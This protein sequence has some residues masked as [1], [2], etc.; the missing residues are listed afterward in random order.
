MP[1]RVSGLQSAG[2]Q[3]VVNGLS[4][5]PP[6]FIE[7]FPARWIICGFEFA[8][9]I[10]V[11]FDSATP[12]VVKSIRQRELLNTWLRLYARQQTAPAIWEYQPARLEEELADLVYYTVDTSTEPPQ[13]TI[14]SEGTRISNAYGH[15][16]KGRLLDDYVGPTLAP[17]VMPIYYKCA[18][19]SL[20]V[21]TISD[22]DD[23]YGRVVAYERL[24]LPFTTDNRVSH[25]VASLKTISV[26][27]GFEIKNLMRGNDALPR[28]RVRA[29]IDRDLFHRA[30]GRIAAADV[31]EFAEQPDPAPPAKSSS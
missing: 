22:I 30:P 7:N 4:L 5:R 31:I 8:W 14:Q 1:I 16:G 21:Y 15:T 25:I 27:G 11:N 20:P 26:D 23:I 13:L 28:P 9:M 2:R 24:L 17:F 19:Y 12:S 6:A 18:A 29:V 3:A 10:V